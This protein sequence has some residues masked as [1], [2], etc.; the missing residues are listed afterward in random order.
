MPLMNEIVD[1][2]EAVTEDVEEWVV[3]ICAQARVHMHRPM[4]L[5]YMFAC[6]MMYACVHPYVADCRYKDTEKSSW[7]Y[8]LLEGLVREGGG[9]WG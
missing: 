9:G 8:S 6:C 4:R 1:V 5:T 3:C 2:L 7:V